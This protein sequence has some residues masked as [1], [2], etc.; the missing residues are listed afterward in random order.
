MNGK[1]LNEC[2]LTVY[3]SLV[4]LS[5]ESTFSSRTPEQSRTPFLPQHLRTSAAS[6]HKNSILPRGH[7]TWQVWGLRCER[8]KAVG[9]SGPATSRA[10]QRFQN[11]K[12]H[13]Y[14]S[15]KPYSTLC[16]P[17]KKSFRA[18]NTHLHSTR[19]P[20]LQKLIAVFNQIHN[21]CSTSA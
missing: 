14:T 11:Q 5:E 9:C 8:H 4:V 15:G 6:L 10:A 17:C 19:L 1:D 3:S 7:V 2:M 13:L 21:P 12:F 20:Q 16:F 18:T